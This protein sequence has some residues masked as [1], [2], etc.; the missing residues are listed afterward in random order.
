MGLL[1]SVKGV[2]Q[3]GED[4]YYDV[5]DG[6]NET[7][8]VYSIVDPIDR[9]FP[10]FALLI[11]AILLLLAG[12]L[13]ALGGGISLGPSD[14]L[15]VSVLD[16]KTIGI[17]GATVTFTKDGTELG[18]VATNARGFATQAGILKDDTIDIRVGKNSYLTAEE[19][20]TIDELPKTRIINLQKESEAIV[21][22]T[23]TL[24][25]DLGSPIRE[26]VTVEFR[27]SNPY[28]P[29]IRA[30]D[31]TA[32]DAGVAKVD[33]PGNCDK[34]SVSVTDSTRFKDVTGQA[35]TDESTI[36][37]LQEA[38]SQGPT[39]TLTA[40]VSDSKGA[41]LDGIQVNL[42][43][44][45]EV[46]RDPNVGPITSSFTSGGQ[47]N[48][49]VVAGDY[50]LK[51]YDTAG[52]FG[53]VASARTTAQA[54]KAVAI[55]FILAEN[56]KGKIRVKVVDN[57][58]KAIIASAKVR[59]VYGAEQEL[60][61]LV[62]NSSGI[63]EFA[64]SR[65]VDYKA[66]GTADGYALGT[67]TGLRL[68][69][70]DYNL[71][72]SKC[73]ATTCGSL[74]VKVTD[75]DNNPV[76]NATVALYS[77]QTN[78]AT[79]YD[80][81]ST[82]INGIAKFLRVNS[83]T[84]YAFAFKEGFSGR[85]DAAA[86]DST[87]S[88][89][90]AADLTVKMEVGEGIVSL[91]VRDGDGSPMP[92]AAVSVID[93]RT[94]ALVKS[95]F[96][97]NDG[98]KEFTL[99]ADRKIYLVVSK[100]DDASYAIYTTMAK[101][102]IP[103]GTQTFDVVLE[104]RILRDNV[105]LK[106]L[107]L[108]LGGLRA[109]T[110]KAGL[111]YTARL[112]LYVPE[113]KDYISTG[114][115][116]RTGDD[117]IVEKDK[118]FIKSVNAPR[119]SQIKAASLQPESAGLDA[120]DYDVT[121]EDAKWVNV[122]WGRLQAGVYEIEAEIT[123]RDSASIGDR[124]PLYY[125]AWADKG[126]GG[127][128]RFPVDGTV[129]KELYANTKQE[130]FQVDTITLC[131]EKF[132]FAATITD[133]GKSGNTNEPI[134]LTESVTETYN[135]RVFNP[136]TL[137]FVVT[138]S[139]EQRIH[140]SANLRIKNADKLVKFFDYR[141]T[142]AETRQT[143]GVLNGFE[144]PFM[145]VGN[146]LPKN[147]VRFDAGFTPQ[148]AGT[149]LVN[150]RLVSDQAIVFDKTISIIISSP[151]ELD[152]QIS[153]QVFL[154]GVENDITVTTKDRATGLEV[155]GAVVR[156]RDRHSNI[157]DS[158]T[159]LADGTAK[160]TLPGQG[161][162]EKLKIE[163]EK[164]NYNV[165]VTE[166]TVSDELLEIRPAQIGMAL[167]TKSR[168]S[169]EEKFTVRNLAPYS[170]TIK[171]IYL[172]GNFRNTIDMVKVKGW[173][174]NS[175]KGMVLGA[176]GQK[177]LMLKGY[178][179]E[180]ARVL[181]ERQSYDAEL[182]VVAGN[183]GREW[184]F[185][186]PVKISVGLGEEVDNPACLVV[187]K[188]EWI[189]NTTGKPEY[190]EVQIQNNC[191]V[192]AK[193]VPLKD[194]EAKVDWKGNQ[195]GTYSLSF[196]LDTDNKQ[197][198]KADLRSG[199]FRKLVGTVRP[200]QVI[201]AILTF[202]PFGGVHGVANADVTIQASSPQD[203]EDQILKNTIKTT[204]TVASL[205]DCL[206]YDKERLVVNQGETGTINVTA[207]DK[208]GEPVKLTL[209]SKLR[210]TP[211]QDFTLEPGKTQAIQVFAEQSDPG[212][213][214]I[215]LTAKFASDTKRQLTK[216]LRVAISAPGCWQISKYEFDVYD[217]PRSELD[218][219]DTA[220]FANTCVEKPVGVRV[221]TKDFLQALKNGLV[222]GIASMGLTLLTNA[223]DPNCTGVFNCTSKGGGA[224]NTLA[225][226][227]Y[228]G[229]KYYQ[230]TTGKWH[231]DSVTGPVVDPGLVPQ[232]SKTAVPYKAPDNQQT[233]P[234]DAK[235]PKTQAKDLQSKADN[236]PGS[237]LN[238]LT[239]VPQGTEVKPGDIGS[240]E[241]KAQTIGS[242]TYYSYDQG[243]SWQDNSGQPVTD[244]QLLTD[245]KYPGLGVTA[246]PA[247]PGIDPF[248]LTS[249][250]YVYEASDGK[251]YKYGQVGT[252]TEKTPITRPG[253]IEQLEKIAQPIG[254]NG[255]KQAI[256]RQQQTGIVS[257][258]VINELVAT[259]EITQMDRPFIGGVDDYVID[260][261]GYLYNRDG[262][263]V[264]DTATIKSAQ[265]K[266]NSA[267]PAQKIT[268]KSGTAPP[269][270]KKIPGEPGT[271]GV[272]IAGAGVQSPNLVLVR[273]TPF[274]VLPTGSGITGYAGT[275][276]GSIMSGVASQLG[277][278]VLGDVLGGGAG[279]VRGL[280]GTSP[281]AAGVLGLVAGTAISYMGQQEEVNFTVMQK[282]AELKQ[283]SMVQ[284]SPP[285]EKEDKEIRL[286]VEGFGTGGA[287][288][289]PQPIVNNPN[290]VSQ[291]S[292]S[293]RLT[294]T[295]TGNFT[296]T[297]DKPKY[298]TLKAEGIRHV[299]KDKTYDKDDFIDEKGGI[300]G[301]V[302]TSSV[303]DKTKTKLEQDSPKPL[304]Q[305]YSLEFN[306]VPPQVET[307]QRP[308]LL[309]NCQAAEKVGA[310]GPDALPKVKLA[311]NWT[312]I[313][314]KSC[315]E[316][317]KEGIYCDATQ[318]SI[319]LLKKIN[320]LSAYVQQRGSSFQCP[321]PI[322]DE[323][324]TNTIGVQDVG[325][326]SV[327]IAKNGTKV[328]VIA[329]LNNTNP[330]EAAAEVR[331]RA[332]KIGAAGEVA[333]PDG[334]QNITINGGGAKEVR[335]TF[336]SLEQGFYQ[337]KVEITPSVS[338]QNCA[339]KAATNALSR[340]FFAG[341]TGLQECAPY[342]T[343]RLDKFIQASGIT[344]A[345]PIV[346]MAKFKARL[347]QD[348]YSTDFQR[349]FDIAQRQAF[350]NAPD[351]YK[352]VPT[353]LGA[354][355]KD[356]ELFSFAA[357]SQPDFT[358]PGA[359]TYDVTIDINYNDGSWQ[360]FDNAGNP[361][362]K[363]TVTMQK[364]RGAEPDSP[365]YYTPFDGLVGDGGRTG[366]GVN[367][368]GDSILIDNGTT[369]V[370][371]VEIAGSSPIENGIFSVSKATGFKSMQ[372]DNSGVVANLNRA[373]GNPQL[374]FQPSNATPVILQIDKRSG[375]DAY[376]VYQVGVDGDAVDVGQTMAK[377]NGVGILCRAFNDEIL[378]QQQNVPDTHMI[379]ASCS[380]AR[381]G[382][383]SLYTLEFCGEPKRF[384]TAS[385]ETIFYTPQESDSF[386]KLSGAASDSARLIGVKAKA[387]NVQLNGNGVTRK[388]TSVQDIFDLVKGEYMCVSQT[389]L[390]TEF[391]WNPKKIYGLINSKE[392]DAINACIASENSNIKA[393]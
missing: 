311:W 82:D 8:P 278:G 121:S 381:S 107:G 315:D 46:A 84:Y 287:P 145:D 228:G 387:Q 356:P 373:N 368:N 48:F 135:A 371:T 213:Y 336:P 235:K 354:Y 66:I 116:L 290:Q 327:S 88:D 284:G 171:D 147:S 365:F 316:D 89:G 221:N 273:N 64:I 258:D 247:G 138:N 217:S 126:A 233:P 79:G 9:V 345:D 160:V 279:L 341:N 300:A 61:T 218:G 193:P 260:A 360:L 14:T 185:K 2:W 70:S 292:E 321:S 342:S 114:V 388:I 172:S 265:D 318:F 115:H 223:A 243:E 200:E 220:S 226:A 91:N 95:D 81:R 113:E 269:G 55:P 144:F 291:G 128:D 124:L 153:P 298:K 62:V 219:F 205:E 77:A 168:L 13:L 325:I 23:I 240:E 36:I 310:T 351:Y 216:N 133:Q 266:W 369:P 151:N 108:H 29:S 75:Q 184:L 167:N 80:T 319:A 231:V 150:I 176:D 386:I 214:P 109:N 69:N 154:S 349:D 305:R 101:P 384:G 283:F 104:K 198:Q 131:D 165:S 378:A 5:L 383:R 22:K 179:T 392:E 122:Q 277:G 248:A 201:S 308:D 199:Y 7:V 182:T 96:T 372:V 330:A 393:G 339:D 268:I 230:D 389:S 1:D 332:L 90:T 137:K 119:A 367:F 314:E 15:T 18:S 170:L 209:E 32:G 375:S 344:G 229:H 322:E 98:N 25:D 130:I 30:Q 155:E 380:V 132:C 106:F 257:A 363:I 4:L 280:F 197:G 227:D 190:T 56:V 58:S 194:L 141:I 53:E 210:T 139:S 20:V 195:I 251:W 244:P 59:L 162:G 189:A 340:N 202:T 44:Y 391:F 103:S 45:A 16:S 127:R 39:G 118:L 361:K 41:P 245:I 158:A 146:L 97:G 183:F 136:Y 10:S 281:W 157:V 364:L 143:G 295:N 152:T 355:F 68:G 102:I 148:K 94:G 3:S 249:G 187:T 294:F 253:P 206:T 19:T 92:F 236:P 117:T 376:A 60:T 329:T 43:R 111:T 237:E 366:Y 57:S 215:Y 74:K 73:T 286:D 374:L 33:V 234:Q 37:H 238:P 357:Y 262:V 343:A 161:P 385:Y 337:A 350:F 125:R 67:A 83:D 156:V 12:G 377:W 224:N 181:S 261:D 288:S 267:N 34:L 309:L 331:I 175:Y 40:N 31:L 129:A 272:V 285:N 347:M 271:A 333:C 76:Q 270:N 123:V 259:G 299:Y 296:T 246:L 264:T 164:P 242:Q 63:A 87:K 324:A 196:N 297:E 225:T 42:Y 276:V 382:D 38:D 212:Q 47:A 191:T 250:E 362:A 49:T 180:D 334:T 86:F 134:N 72:L 252:S 140:N 85:S 163:V 353:G 17:E 338:C 11:I 174:D 323:A 232:L 204:I 99:R 239:G 65:D 358:L 370:R 54:G 93:A 282:D 149:G 159:T 178:L 27:C 207:T 52:V 303:L 379:S 289:A 348:G 254:I 203:N 313:D 112:K 21:Q 173:L 208:C 169:A 304:E 326:E 51:T 255:N 24:V 120:Q 328:D 177:E 359:G 166:I 301:Q 222:W 263:I 293:F 346:K 105:E 211:K 186:V 71:N 274:V 335:C 320:A 352:A 6:I 26:A 306:S 35:I 241:P 275:G 110:L 256:V 142:N 307:A 188:S 302:F 390:N 100:K 28:A 317:N 312:A 50:V 192:G 78:S